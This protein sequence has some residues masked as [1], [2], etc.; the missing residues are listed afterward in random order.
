MARAPFEIG[1]ATV[2]PGSRLSIEFPVARLPHG[3]HAA[4]PCMV[5]H[6]RR[7]GPTLWLTAA[8][9]G[10]ELTGVEVIRR[11]LAR[12]KTRAL[13]GTILAVPMVNVFGITEG[14]RYLPDRRD[15]NRSFPGSAKGSLAARLA[16]LLMTEIVSRGDYGVDI[17]SGSDHRENLA[18]VRANL[19]DPDTLALA[20]AF[21]APILIDARERAGSLRGEA[22]AR[23]SRVLLFEAGAPHRFDEAG[24][25]V[26]EAGVL[27]VLGALGMT[28]SAPLDHRTPTLVSHK[29]AWSRAA[30]GGLF[31]VEV[32]L[33]ARVAK[34]A[35]LGT[36]ADVFGGNSSK[37]TARVA[38]LVIGLRRNPVVYQGDALA[39]V[40]D[41]TAEGVLPGR[42]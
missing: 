11:V 26:G 38:G 37:V 36:V 25:A 28:P 39:H 22:A 7:A 4:L 8:V 30:R 1:G 33:G 40:A 21:G 18:Q 32:D 17:H 35:H 16:H 27:R 13:S 34:D 2:P 3:A 42:A 23:G 15:L 29:T 31:R 12:V 24:V 6:G 20:L 9:H 41:I 14:S 5:V 10:D 19:K